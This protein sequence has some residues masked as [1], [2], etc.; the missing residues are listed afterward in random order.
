M[1][2]TTK[3]LGLDPPIF[4]NKLYQKLCQ[5]KVDI[6]NMNT[7]IKIMENG[8]YGGLSVKN[9][10]FV[11]SFLRDDKIVINYE[12]DVQAGLSGKE[13]NAVAAR[14]LSVLLRAI[15]GR[16]AKGTTKLGAKI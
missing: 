9:R 7:D 12:A 8:V 11:L 3:T 14:V 1:D 16:V 6:S 13:L 15:D 4:R 10:I 2:A 5:P